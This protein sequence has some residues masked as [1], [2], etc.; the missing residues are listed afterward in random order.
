MSWESVL[1]S[2]VLVAA[3]EMGDKTQL[4]AFSLASKFRKPWVVLAG[5][6]VAT[7]AN[8]A[9]ASSVGA[10]VSVHVPARVMA[11]ILAV[12]F[13]G[14]GLWTLKPDTL[15]DD[16]GKPPRFGAF[17]TTVVLF[18]LAE[19]GDKTQ[20]AT[21]ALA[22]RYQSLVM[23]TVGSTAGMLVADGLAVFLGDRLA[24]RV[25]MKWV[26]WAT[27]S[28]FFIFGAVSLWTAWRG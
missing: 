9:L 4:L 13:L 28:L 27:A 12:M 11:L 6:L 2:F 7:I 3:S 1:G 21:M 17:L 22:A 19:M 5:I 10:W 16:D 8:H 15:D 20:L 24:G 26:R 14:F 18:F 23:V 25:Q